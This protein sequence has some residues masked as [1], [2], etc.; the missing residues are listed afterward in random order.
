MIR[1]KLVA[2][3]FA[4]I[5]ALAGFAGCTSEGAS[6]PPPT[7][8]P[9]PTFTPVPSPTPAPTATPGSSNAWRSTNNGIEV[10]GAPAVLRVQCH[11]PE[12]GW[13]V[14]VRR[15]ITGIYYTNPR[16]SGSAL[17]PSGKTHF[18]RSSE[19]VAY[20]DK[21]GVIFAPP[22]EVN[23]RLLDLLR[24]GAITLQLRGLSGESA[25]FPVEHFKSAVGGAGADGCPIPG[26]S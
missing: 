26:A 13:F 19:W 18:V 6:A 12:K 11:V 22:R 21:G 20:Q 4:S 24:G 5:M 7:S 9:T 14:Q 15:N 1:P 23:R 17:M 10:F 3:A 16:V 25:T 8:A 2:L